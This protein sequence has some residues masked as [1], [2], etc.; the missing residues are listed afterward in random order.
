[1]IGLQQKHQSRLS[2]CFLHDS[3]VDMNITVGSDGVFEEEIKS[4]KN[5]S[6]P[7]LLPTSLTLNSFLRNRKHQ[8]KFPDDH[9]CLHEAVLCCNDNNIQIDLQPVTPHAF[10]FHR[11]ILNSYKNNYVKNAVFKF[12]RILLCDSSF[13]SQDFLN[14]TENTVKDKLY[15]ADEAS[16]NRLSC[17]INIIGLFELTAILSDCLNG[18][19][20]F[21]KSHSNDDFAFLNLMKHLNQ[22]KQV[23]LMES[24]YKVIGDDHQLTPETSVIFNRYGVLQ[25]LNDSAGSFSWFK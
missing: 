17:Q 2:N 9:E 7:R 19:S 8:K 18:E 16:A 20:Y 22:S 1:M 10:L 5:V 12:P 3:I 11:Y 13:T 4:E 6:S 15:N 24:C 25:A 23:V 14:I 21:C